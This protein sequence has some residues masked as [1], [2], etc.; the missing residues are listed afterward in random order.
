MLRILW[1]R[2]VRR[3]LCVVASVIA[4][5]AF[6]ATSANAANIALYSSGNG[7]M[8]C[9]NPDA[10]WN[11]STNNGPA[12]ILSPACQ[13]WYGGWAANTAQSSWI[14]ATT[15]NPTPPA[16]YTFSETFS[17]SGYILNTA[18][19][20]GT[21]YVDD[22]G[23]LSINGIPIDTE[24]RTFNGVS[25]TVPDADLVAGINTLS[26][27]MTAN[28]QTDDGIRVEISQ[29]TA[30]TPEPGTLVMLGSGVLAGIGVFRRKLEL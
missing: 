19:I 14:G 2:Q 5:V 23:T 15:T 11:V 25:F 1:C 26:V 10:H 6:I 7:D 30:D 12:L 18:V 20:T 24:T 22:T 13:N 8:T 16:P 17:M 28:D 9:G 29:A 3:K 27:T 4:A 21:W